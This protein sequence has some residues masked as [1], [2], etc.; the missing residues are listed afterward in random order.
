MRCYHSQEREEC[1]VIVADKKDC[2]GRSITA[3]DYHLGANFTRGYQ[4]LQ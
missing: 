1:R 2:F 3:Q 4:T